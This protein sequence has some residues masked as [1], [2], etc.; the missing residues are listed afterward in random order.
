[1]CAELGWGHREEMVH[2]GLGREAMPRPWDFFP[3]NGK[4]L[5]DFK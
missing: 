1:M 5:R 3:G 2:V 4:P